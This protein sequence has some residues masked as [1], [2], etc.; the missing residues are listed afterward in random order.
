MMRLKD[1]RSAG[2]KTFTIV[3]EK[4]A[5][6]QTLTLREET[7]AQHGL[8]AKPNLDE[9][10]LARIQA[11]DAFYQALAKALDLLARRDHSEAALA[12]KLAAHGRKVVDR[13]LA[14]L[15]EIG[16]VD[17][18]KMIREW[19]EEAL[20][21]S[22]QGPKKLRERFLKEGFSKELVEETLTA[23]DEATQE[24]KVRELFAKTLRTLPPLPPKKAEEKLMRAALRQGFAYDIL[25]PMAS[26]ARE[27]LEEETDVEPL[28]CERI[29]VLESKYPGRDH[30]TKERFMQKLLREGFPYELV[31]KH[32]DRKG[33]KDAG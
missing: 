4:D 17:D 26:E 33:G 29:S 19:F 14:H 11:D 8:F 12:Q 7:V 1:I 25:R 22:L 3:L 5:E 16:Y 18:A 27:R 20:A 31:R 6:E 13:V 24:E 21:F 23:Y 28:L 15:R 2:K 10:T 30:K 32:L 9:S